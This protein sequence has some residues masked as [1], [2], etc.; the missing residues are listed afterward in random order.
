MH[1][2]NK[3]NKICPFHAAR[4]IWVRTVHLALISCEPTLKY[5]VRQTSLA[6]T[7]VRVACKYRTYLRTM[8]LGRDQVHQVAVVLAPIVLHGLRCAAIPRGLSPGKPPTARCLPLFLVP[9]LFPGPQLL[10]WVE[11]PSGQPPPLPLRARARS[12]PTRGEPAVLRHEENPVV[13][14]EVHHMGHHHRLSLVA[15]K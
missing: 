10:P 12:S 4:S 15:T 11:V 1:I 3:T 6:S 13:S 7:A 5:S 8:A 14:Q 2:E 9:G